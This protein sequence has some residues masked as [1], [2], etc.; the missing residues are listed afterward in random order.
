[1]I[2]IS[3]VLF[4]NPVQQIKNL[5]L[6]LSLNDQIQHI[7]LVDNSPNDDLHKL[8]SID[9][10]IIYIHNPSNPGYGSAH[11]IAINKSISENVAYHV[12][13]NPDILMGNNV[14]ASLKS[15]MDANSDVANI[16]PDI[17]YPDGSRQHLC[18]L[19]P[20]PLSLFSRRFLPKVISDKFNYKYN[21]LGMNYTNEM[22]VPLLSGCFMFL[23]VSALA[24]VGVF[25]PRYFMYL[26]D[27]DLNRRLHAKYKTMFLPSVQVTHEYAKGSYKNK[28]L[29]VYHIKSAI[30][31]FNKWG[32]FID[33]NRKKINKNC[34]G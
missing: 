14:L 29:M 10:R 22:N 24:E 30:K 23:R 17:R 5:L 26:E 13:V 32:W 20:T 27:F 4:C 18:K 28:K 21:L 8:T 2:N 6:D 15:Y 25:D 19:L 7:Y 1:M 3:V 33:V 16:M 31:Y 11:N 12:V 9:S 34:T